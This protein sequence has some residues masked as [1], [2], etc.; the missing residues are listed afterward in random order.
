[1]SCPAPQRGRVTGHDGGGVARISG[2]FGGRG[3]GECAAGVG[4]DRVGA[5]SGARLVAAGEGV[6]RGALPGRVF[7]LA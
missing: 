3:A 7:A 1:M 5:E 4:L 6:E 2:W